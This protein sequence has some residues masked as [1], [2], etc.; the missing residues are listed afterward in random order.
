[1]DLQREL[2]QRKIDLP[3]IFI[4]GHGDIPMSVQAMKR[5]AVDFLTKPFRDQ[6]LLDAI[7]TA[8]Q[9]DQARREWARA[10]ADVGQRYAT[11]TERERE[12]MAHV[13]AGELNKQIA[14]ALGLTEITI[15]V[16]RGNAMRKMQAR[17]LADLV[18]MADRLG[19]THAPAGNAASRLGTATG[20]GG[21]AI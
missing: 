10:L 4:T 19:V 8:L 16:H 18:R 1:M 20:Q 5:G 9:K 3:I 2:I 14:A 15:K 17:S 21:D 13:V 12:V 7:S 6:E 11:L